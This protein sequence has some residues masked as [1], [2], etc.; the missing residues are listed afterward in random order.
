MS[1]SI[2]KERLIMEH[3][4]NDSLKANKIHVKFV[5]FKTPLSGLASCP[6]KFYFK[7]RFFTFQTVRTDYVALRTETDLHG[8]SGLK[9]GTSY[10]LQKVPHRNT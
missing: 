9:P 7:V 1:S 3:E 4:K 5:S 6:K 2:I 10:F 8:N